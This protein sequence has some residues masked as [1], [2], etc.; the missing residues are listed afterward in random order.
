LRIGVC[1]LRQAGSPSSV[2]VGLA[3]TTSRPEHAPIERLMSTWLTAFGPH[4]QPGVTPRHTFQ[5]KVVSSLIALY[6][7]L[8]V[9]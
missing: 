1:P 7:P 9:G 3:L 2:G 6:W 8:V 5:R 4:V